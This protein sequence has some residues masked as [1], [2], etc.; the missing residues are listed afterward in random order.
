MNIYIH[1]E[2]R[3]AET[4]VFNKYND[5]DLICLDIDIHAEHHGYST[6]K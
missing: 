5:N 3:D 6:T 1:L 4:L 2:Y